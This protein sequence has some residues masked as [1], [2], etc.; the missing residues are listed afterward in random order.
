MPITM[1]GVSKE[2]YNT[3]GKS[4]GHFRKIQP[5]LKKNGIINSNKNGKLYHAYK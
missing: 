4:S 2:E 5:S 3:V 1:E